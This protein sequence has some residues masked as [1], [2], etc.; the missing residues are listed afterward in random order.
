MGRT[1]RFLLLG[2]AAVVAA[3]AGA[4][5]ALALSNHTY[6]A[7]RSGGGSS[8]TLAAPCITLQSAIQATS[9]GGTISIVEPGDP[10]NATIPKALTIR[11]VVTEGSNVFPPSITPVIEIVAGAADVVVLEGLHL[12]GGGIRFDSGGHLHV[13][14]CVL[15]NGGIPGAAGILFQPTSASRL[16]VRNTVIS[17]FGSGTGGGIVVN[18]Q[19]GG[20]ARVD[21][22][23]VSI[24]GSAFGIAAD[25][26][27]SIAGINLS[28]INSVI[29]GNAQDGVVAVTTA[30]S[31]P[32]A[33]LLTNTSSVNN[34]NG[35]RVIGPNMTVRLEQ[36]KVVGNVTGL[37]ATGGGALLSAGNNIVQANGS[38]TG[39]VPLN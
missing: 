29:G 31:A 14:N 33:V 3:G 28:I 26:S 35:V 8:C 1:L 5:P 23:H 10:G 7:P 15:G 38:F 39:S 22:E 19:A 18:P 4:A 17:N 27:R 16:S 2:V 13:I 37:A 25:G 9:P 32:G 36:S 11:S 24:K 6:V 12:D 30:G 20:S 34:N 21:L